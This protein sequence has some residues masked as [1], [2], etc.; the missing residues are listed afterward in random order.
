M[1]YFVTK[2]PSPKELEEG[3]TFEEA[4][5]REHEF[6][7]HEAPWRDQSHLEPRMGT[8]NL[9]RALSNLLARVINDG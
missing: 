2:Q 7:A 5:R 1:G 9:T 4:R 8:K 3:V 6:F